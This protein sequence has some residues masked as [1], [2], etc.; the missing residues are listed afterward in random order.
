MTFQDFKVR[1]DA[2]DRAMRANDQR[3]RA[4]VVQHSE[5]VLLQDHAFCEVRE[6]DGERFLVVFGEH[7][8]AVIFELAEVRGYATFD[9]VRPEP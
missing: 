3:L 2:E 5:G 1:I 6:H 8:R 4:C 7:I 9:L